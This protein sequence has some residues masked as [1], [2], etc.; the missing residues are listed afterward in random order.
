MPRVR[1]LVTALALTMGAGGCGQ[2]TQVP[3]RETA[4]SVPA[5]PGTANLTWTPVTQNIDGTVATG[6][7]GYQ[8]F[9]GTSPVEMTSVIIAANP[10]Q[11]SYVVTNLGSGTW[12]FAV[13][14]YTGD[15][16]IGLMSNVASKTID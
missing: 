3:G 5:A 16:T 15:G 7:A 9:Y 10:G 8:V 4:T 12:Y 6:L 2:V 1:G 14:A 13:A 11:T